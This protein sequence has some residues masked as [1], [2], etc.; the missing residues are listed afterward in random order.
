MG[1]NLLIWE[2]KC[3][4]KLLFHCQNN[5]T[6]VSP[7]ISSLHSSTNTCKTTKTNFIKFLSRTVSKEGPNK[8]RPFYCCA[9]PRG[10]G[11]DFFEWGDTAESSA[12]SNKFRTG[13]SAPAN[14][15]A[16]KKRKCGLCQQEGRVFFNFVQRVFLYSKN[17]TWL[18]TKE[19][20]AFSIVVTFQ[21]LGWKHLRVPELLKAMKRQSVLPNKN[22]CLSIFSLFAGHTKRTCPMN[23]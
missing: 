17:S 9:K 16:I 19:C 2:Q 4:R 21:K 18:V 11:C 8:G 7:Y 1:F 13:R 15:G 10:Q 5:V 22:C 23:R 6:H 12:S 14:S 20:L 3:L